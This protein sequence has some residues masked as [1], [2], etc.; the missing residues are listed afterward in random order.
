VT[1]E[2]DADGKVAMWQLV[3]EDEVDPNHG[4]ISH[5]S[6][7]GLAQVGKRVDDEVKAKTAGAVRA[8]AVVATDY[9]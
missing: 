9:R 1:V 7:L 4:R 8:S 6:P 5:R 3:G 2:D